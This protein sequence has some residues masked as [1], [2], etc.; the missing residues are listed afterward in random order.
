MARG[1]LPTAAA[2]GRPA[3]D[4]STWRSTLEAREGRDHQPLADILSRSAHDR[5]KPAQTA[6]R[7]SR[8][9]GARTW[10]A[11][12]APEAGCSAGRPA[13]T[14]ATLQDGPRPTPGSTPRF[15]RDR[16]ADRGD[17]ACATARSAI[18]LDEHRALV[19]AVHRGLLEGCS[20]RP[21]PAL[22]MTSFEPLGRAD[23]RDLPADGPG[24]EATRIRVGLESVLPERADGTS[25]AG[26]APCPTASMALRVASRTETRATPIVPEF[27]SLARRAGQA[28]KVPTSA[29]R[30]RLT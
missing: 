13:R 2:R 20:A 24:A 18:C 7:N 16:Q 17:H 30:C 19:C 3:A 14:S 26:A 1:D 4:T 11:R 10:W 23:S 22:R 21:G 9:S 29:S 15:R 27:N 25:D 6:P 12:Y 8:A 5:R 28:A